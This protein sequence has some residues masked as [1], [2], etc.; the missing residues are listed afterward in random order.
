MIK[1]HG[2]KKKVILVTISKTVR[3]IK[4]IVFMSNVYFLRSIRWWYSKS[5]R[6][7]ILETHA[8]VNLRLNE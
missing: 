3:D 6:S 8:S 2:S 4:N 7:Y 5:D 1:T